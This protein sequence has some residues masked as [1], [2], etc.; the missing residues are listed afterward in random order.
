MKLKISGYLLTNL[1]GNFQSFHKEKFSFL[2]RSH[3]KKFAIFLKV[4]GA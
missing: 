3:R 4:K 1:V 2:F